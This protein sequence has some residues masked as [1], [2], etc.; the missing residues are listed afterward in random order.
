IERL[1]PVSGRVCLRL[2]RG[3]SLETEG[4]KTGPH[5]QHLQ[6]LLYSVLSGGNWPA[7]VY[8]LLQALQQ[9]YPELFELEPPHD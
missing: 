2:L 8:A 6:L 7:E 4:W 9:L 1:T 3:L 5:A